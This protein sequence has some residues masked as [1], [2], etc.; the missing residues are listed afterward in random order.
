MN[1][2]R[3]VKRTNFLAKGFNALMTLNQWRKAG[4]PLRD[5]ADV[6]AIF[7]EHCEA[8]P[9]Y[10]PDGRANPLGLRGICD[11]ALEL[12]GVRGCGCHV[13]P[14]ATTFSN[15]LTVPVKPCPRGLF[16]CEQ[17]DE[18]KQSEIQLK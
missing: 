13:S 12:D 3:V 1:E 6:A 8:C 2:F 16:G 11:D 14:D 9:L 17:L 15:V 18:S 7:N 10:N 4:Y 5:P